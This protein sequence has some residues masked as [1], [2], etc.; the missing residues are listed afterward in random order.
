MKNSFCNT[1]NLNVL[2]TTLIHQVLHFILYVQHFLTLNTS[3]DHSHI[4]V[5]KRIPADNL[6]R[7]LFVY[8]LNKS[9]ASILYN[10]NI[11]YSPFFKSFGLFIYISI[12]LLI[13]QFIH[14]TKIQL[15]KINN[16]LIAHN[17][18]NIIKIL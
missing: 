10:E 12:N 11:K 8:P 2:E 3:F 15:F 1:I 17:I 13:S 14:Y 16:T 4:N 7:N 9:T 18:I 5:Y 6:F